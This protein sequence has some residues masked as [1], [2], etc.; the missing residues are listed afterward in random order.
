MPMCSPPQGLCERDNVFLSSDRF[1]R[2]ELLAMGP[3][4]AVTIMSVAMVATYCIYHIYKFK[5]SLF[6]PPALRND[7][8]IIFE[9][10]QTIVAQARYPDV[11][12]PYPPSAVS[13]FYGLGLGG[14]AIF[15]SLWTALEV[16]ALVVI[17]RAALAFERDEIRNAWLPLG[18]LGVFLADMP[19]S[20]D[21]RGA[22]SNLIFLGLL[23]A[24][25]GSLKARPTLAG[26]MV[27]LSV[28]VK[29]FSGLV[30]VW[31]LFNG[32]RRVV[33]AGIATT[34]VCWLLFP[35]ALVGFEGTVNLYRDWLQQLHVLGDVRLH[36]QLLASASGP[37]LVTLRRAIVDATGAS[38]ESGMTLGIL[39]SLWGVWTAALLW[40]VARGGFRLRRLAP[41]RAAFADWCVLLLAPLPF[42]PWLEPGHVVPLLAVAM[43]SIAIF[44]DETSG[45]LE[46]FCAATIGLVLALA[47][48][49]APPFGLR[50]FGILAQLFVVVV[51]LGWMRPRLAREKPAGLRV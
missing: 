38:F 37:S 39:Y 44:Y 29:L 1:P 43:L 4:P 23:L 7:A 3:S 34:A 6:W 15:I 2:R 35:V 21:L 24:G 20:W 17:M 47:V 48:V 32:P 33:I 31:L 8:T 22:S 45:S 14:P 40:Y 50:G 26:V 36:E 16:T 41:S 18:C 19:V 11:I 27:G 25:W 5:L 13:I 46:R 30:L 51:A 9:V 10:P 12:F 42:S 49:F 28:C